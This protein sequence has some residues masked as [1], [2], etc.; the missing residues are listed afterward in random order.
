M[1]FFVSGTGR[2][3][4]YASVSGTEIF[5]PP[6]PN[7]VP[8]IRHHNFNY[9]LINE[10]DILTANFDFFGK[11]LMPFLAFL[12]YKCNFNVDFQKVKKK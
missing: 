12:L 8:E 5:V 2:Q 1:V 7:P 11:F 9:N 10:T 6:Y 4:F 3:R